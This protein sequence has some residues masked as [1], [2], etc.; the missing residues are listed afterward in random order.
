MGCGQPPGSP[1]TD[2]KPAEPAP[3]GVLSFG[4]VSFNPAQEFEVFRPFANHVVDRL[5]HVGIGRGRVE[6]AGS[7]SQMVE[8]LRKGR[9]DVFID[10]PFPAAFVWTHGDMT[11]ILRR[12]KRGADTYRSVVFT[13]ADNG[14]DAVTDLTGKIIAFGEPFSTTGFLLPKAALASAGQRLVHYADP[15]AS[16]PED[17]VG[18][19]FSNDAENTIF[20]VLKGKVAAGAVNADYYEALAG[21]LIDELQVLHLTRAVPRNVVCV[22]NGLDS[23]LVEAIQEVLLEMHLDDEGRAALLQF[24]QTSRFDLFPGGVDQD[25]SEIKKLLTQVEE[26][27]GQ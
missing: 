7:L 12:W 5:H 13:R 18:Y 25:L 15:A 9:V 11:P 8:M 23:E 2:V 6:V 10:S 3:D 4:S 17:R 16:V 1:A 22:R 26:D 24:Q 21:E 19:V 20:W 14:V 27:L